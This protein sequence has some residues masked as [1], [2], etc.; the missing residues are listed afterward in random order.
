[1]F[2]RD[3]VLTIALA[4]GIAGPLLLPAA[5]LVRHPSG[6]SA[7]NEAG[8][9]ATLV[10]NSCGLVAGAVLLS[11]PLGVATA[12]FLERSRIP[13]AGLLR[14]LVTLGL[15]IPLPVYAAA[16]QSGLG[17]VLR[18]DLGGWRPWRQGLLP[19]IGVHAVA[20]FPWVIWIVS[21]GL[22]TADPRLEEDALLA[23]GRW[24]VWRG[25]L[26]PR[27]R[28][29]AAVAACGIAVQAL[30]ETTVTDV[31][32]VRTFAEEIYFQLVGNPAGVSAAVAVTLPVW[33]L[34]AAGAIW[35]ARRLALSTPPNPAEPGAA[36]SLRLGSRAAW[37]AGVVLWL[38]AVV[39]VGLPLA[40]LVAKTGGVGQIVRVARVHGAAL[41]DS[42]LWSALAG[43]G[44]ACLALAACRL[45]RGSRRFAGFLLV[46]SATAWITPAPLIGLGLK[47]AIALLVSGEEAALAELNL[48][49]EFPPLRS[50]LYDQPSPLPGV[51]AA[52]IRFFPIAVALLWPTVRSLPRDLLDAAKLDG[53]PRAEWRAVVWPRTRAALIRAAVAVAVLSLG[54]VVAGKLVQPPGRPS[55][56]Q[57]LFNAMHYGADA[58][59]AAMS[60]LQI[61]VTAGLCAVFLIVPRARIG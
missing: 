21:H 17:I 41:A 23:G 4:A 10:G 56:V 42:L 35:V 6:G 33:L 13:G 24:A 2:L 11:V 51:W 58:T 36:H 18:P 8:R 32:M 30:T 45:A 47:E 50:L 25:V 55:F 53:G 27:V 39:L 40:G 1:M 5:D 16:W 19:A 3:R 48:T 9:L 38:G 29:A 20:G 12:A 59:V 15:F 60:L 37:L 26:W 57:E 52:V 22:R 28:L 44:A 46:L 54:E 34:C 14:P 61:A 43:I 49:P 7:W 31:M